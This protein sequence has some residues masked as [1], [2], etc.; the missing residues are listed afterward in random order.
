MII[1]WYSGSRIS[2]L[3]SKA[4]NQRVIV[5]KNK[6]QGGVDDRQYVYVLIINNFKLMNSGFIT[7]AICKKEQDM[8]QD[9]KTN[10]VVILRQQLRR[11][12]LL[13]R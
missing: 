5:W 8:Y 6:N 1:Y 10:T 3:G 4:E 11:S 9:R 7:V 2:L 13:T 12:K